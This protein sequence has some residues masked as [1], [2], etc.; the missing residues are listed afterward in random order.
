MVVSPHE[1]LK[2]NGAW[3][4]TP[5][6]CQCETAVTQAPGPLPRAS[7]L[8]SQLVLRTASGGWSPQ[9]SCPTGGGREAQ[10]G[11]AP[12]G[13]MEKPHPVRQL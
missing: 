8:L 11:E 4:V 12:H 1:A 7:R 2:P 10:R 3:E 6:R 13:N 5:T 9:Q